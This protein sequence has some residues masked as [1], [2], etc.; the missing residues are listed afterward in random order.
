MKIYTSYQ[1][2]KRISVDPLNSL[3]IKRLREGTK[4]DLESRLE[5]KL[6]HLADFEA[7]SKKDAL[8]IARKIVLGIKI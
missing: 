5:K 8:T 7:R 4:R 6:V 1:I 2:E 3:V